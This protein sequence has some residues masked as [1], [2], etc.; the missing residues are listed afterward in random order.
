GLAGQPPLRHGCHREHGDRRP[1][2][3]RLGAPGRAGPRQP[4]PPTDLQ[5][6]GGW[7]YQTEWSNGASE[8]GLGLDYLQQRYYDPVIGRFISPDR[9]EFAG[10][11]NLYEYTEDDPVNATDPLCLCIDNRNL[12]QKIRDA[13]DQWQEALQAQAVV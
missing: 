7:G 1:E 4:Q 2:L 8:P 13:W 10:G 3:R 5:W 6:A 9:I 11:P 12:W